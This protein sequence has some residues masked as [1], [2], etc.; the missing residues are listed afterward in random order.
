MKADII[1][2][3]DDDMGVSMIDTQESHVAR[4]EGEERYVLLC[5]LEYV[6][7]LESQWAGIRTAVDKYF[8]E[9]PE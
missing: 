5:G 8:G 1:Y 3:T 4:R 7:I 9:K 2:K 6:L